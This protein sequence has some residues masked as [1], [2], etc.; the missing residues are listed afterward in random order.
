MAIE[1]KYNVTVTEDASII[2]TTGVQG[3]PGIGI[4]ELENVYAQQIDFI[5]D[6]EFYRG[7]AVPGSLTS[8]AVWRIRKIVVNPTDGDTS[9]TWADGDSEFDNIWDNRLSLSY[10]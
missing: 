6:D 8:G 3:P 4:E 2:V 5:T 7:E 9:T 10:S 1:T